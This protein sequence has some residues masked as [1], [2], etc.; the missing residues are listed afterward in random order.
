VTFLAHTVRGRAIT[1]HGRR[2]AHRTLEA[3]TPA[4]LIPRITSRASTV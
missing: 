4:S 1:A 3:R 2:S